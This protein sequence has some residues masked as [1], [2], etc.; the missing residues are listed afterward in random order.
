MSQKSDDSFKRK[1]S[2]AREQSVAG[3]GRTQRT[4]EEPMGV[5]G[6]PDR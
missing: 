5:I 6:T 1:S 4:P 3:S 2:K